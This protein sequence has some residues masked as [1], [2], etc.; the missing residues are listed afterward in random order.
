ML[1]ILGEPSRPASFCDRI[2][3]RAMLQVGALGAFGLGLPG[4]LRA[5]SGGRLH[6]A[7]RSKKSVILVWFFRDFSGRVAAG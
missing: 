7:A 6:P 5:E 3:R 2:P 4:L 1:T